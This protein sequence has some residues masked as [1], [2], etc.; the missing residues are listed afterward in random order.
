MDVPINQNIINSV[1]ITATSNKKE[2][3]ASYLTI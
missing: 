1:N 2:K 3:I